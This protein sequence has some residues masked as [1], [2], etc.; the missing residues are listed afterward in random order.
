[1]CHKE[2]VLRRRNEFQEGIEG[3]HGENQYS[4]GR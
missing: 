4:D 2:G 3:V 1:M